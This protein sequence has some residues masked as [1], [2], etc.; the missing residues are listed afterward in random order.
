[1]TIFISGVGT[2]NFFSILH[3]PQMYPQ[4]IMQ[5]LLRLESLA[6][7]QLRLV[8]VMQ[9]LLSELDGR[10]LSSSEYR[11]PSDCVNFFTVLSSLHLNVDSSILT[12]RGT[13]TCRTRSLIGSIIPME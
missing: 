8:Q 1:M 7:R 3:E 10:R 4:Q 9:L 13:T 6:N 11:L 2:F 12:K 5:V